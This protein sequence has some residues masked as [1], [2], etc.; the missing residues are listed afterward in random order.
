MGILYPFS[1]FS[2]WIHELCHGLAAIMVGGSISK[3]MIY[4]DATGLA[5]T[6][7]N[8][9]RA[10]F[11]ASAGYQGTAVIGCLLLL[12]IRTEHGPRLGTMIIALMMIVSCSLWI[13]NVFGLAFISCFSVI[14]VGVAWK[15]PSMY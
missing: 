8:P 11:I 3:I 15:L 14:L 5:Y 12:F 2:T 13:R 1:I 10:G 6:Y 4:P 9:D 7:A